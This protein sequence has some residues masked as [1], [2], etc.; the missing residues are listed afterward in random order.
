[1]R[2]LLANDDGIHAP[3]LLALA[4][5]LAPGHELVVAAPSEE[6]SATSH[7]ITLGKPM[8]SREVELLPGVAAFSVDGSPADCVKFALAK[9]CP[10]SPDLVVSGINRGPNTGVDIRYSGTVAA[11]ME[12]A[13]S[14]LPAVALSLGDVTPPLRFPA[15]ALTARRVI[16][17]LVSGGFPF[18]RAVA[19]VNLPNLDAPLGVR[20]TRVNGYRYRATFEERLDP[21]GRPYYWMDGEKELL[22]DADPRSDLV[23][24]REGY[25]SVTP[26]LIDPTAFLFLPDL[27]AALDAVG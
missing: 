22:G 23:A 20:A 10:A 1:M 17:A 11:A 6:R 4:K 9:L 14:G 24:V 26:L 2:I 25:V 16:E 7:A 21:R 5:A 12:A 15:A 27:K 3:G 19:N 18:D 13:C 8:R